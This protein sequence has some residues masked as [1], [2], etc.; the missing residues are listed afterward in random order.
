MNEMVIFDQLPKVNLGLDEQPKIT[1]L[2]L[3]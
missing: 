1:I 2:G 3:G